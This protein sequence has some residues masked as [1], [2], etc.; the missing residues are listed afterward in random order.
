MLV[1]P[2]MLLYLGDAGDDS[3]RCIL[4]YKIDQNMVLGESYAALRFLLIGSVAGLDA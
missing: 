4:R 2:A 1:M 3:M